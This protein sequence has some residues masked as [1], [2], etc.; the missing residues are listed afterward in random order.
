MKIGIMGGTFDPIHNGHLMLGEYAYRKFDLDE[1]WFMP[2]GN[3]PHK[4]NQTIQT[5]SEDRKEMVKCAIENYPYF[6]LEP[7]EINR[8]EISYSYQTMEYFHAQYPEHHFFFIIGADSLFALERWKYPDRILKTCTMLAAFRDDKSTRSIM[9]S[10]INELNQKYQADIRLLITPVLS[11]ASSDLRQSMLLGEDIE[12]KVPKEVN[13]YIQ[14][15]HLY[16]G[17]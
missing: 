16:K 15:H 9:E 10:K 8:T 12:G 6:R 14:M 1:V 17:V 3:P 2:N 4:Q 5:T 7:Y 11:V 13:D